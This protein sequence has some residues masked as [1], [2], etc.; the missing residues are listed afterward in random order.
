M[1]TIPRGQRQKLKI[2][3]YYWNPKPKFLSGNYLETSFLDKVLKRLKRKE[4][5][6]VRQ[7][8][9]HALSVW[10]CDNCGTTGLQDTK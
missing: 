6:V 10:D 8:A 3:A 7:L 4:L 5:D 2:F 9:G 1:Q